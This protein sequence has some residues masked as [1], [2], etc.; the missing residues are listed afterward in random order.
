M[1]Q[2]DLTWNEDT[3]E[4]ILPHNE[5]LRIYRSNGGTFSVYQFDA[6]FEIVRRWPR[7]PWQEIVNYINMIRGES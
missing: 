4:I 5:T 3:A 7:M 6:D 1:T 2:Q